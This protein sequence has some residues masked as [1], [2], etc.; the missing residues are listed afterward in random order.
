MRNRASCVVHRAVLAAGLVVGVGA[1]FAA[2][3]TDGSFVGA[4]DVTVPSDKNK[5]AITDSAHQGNYSAAMAFNNEYT[6]YAGRYVVPVSKIPY[7]VRYQF[8]NDLQPKLCGYSITPSTDS[9][10]TPSRTPKSWTF[11]GSN[12]GV[13]WT[14]LGAES[15]VTGWKKG[16]TRY[17]TADDTAGYTYFQ[18]HVTTHNG[19]SAYASLGEVE[20]Y[21]RDVSVNVVGEPA[22]YG[23]AAGIVYGVDELID[24]GTEKTFSVA[25]N[26]TV[27][28]ED[29]SIHYVPVSDG[30]RAVYRGYRFEDASEATEAAD[31]SFTRTLAGVKQNTLTWRWQLRN[32]TIATAGAGGVVK[33]GPRAPGQQATLWIDDDDSVTLEAVPDEGYKFDSWSGDVPD[34]S[35]VNEPTITVPGSIKRN[36]TATF[37]EAHHKATTLIFTPI[38]TEVDWD[39]SANAWNG[40]APGDG[41][42]ILIP[43]LERATTLTLT[44]DTP[45]LAKIDIGKNVTLVVANWNTR[46]LVTNTFVRN[47]GAIAVKGALSMDA[48]SNRVWIVGQN[49][50]IDAGGKITA[51]EAGYAARQG[52]GWTGTSCPDYYGGVYGG[53]QGYKENHSA[54]K[55][56]GSAEWP[57]DPGT[58]GSGAAGGGAIRIDL[59]GTLTVNGTITANGGASKHVNSGVNSGGGSGGGIAIACETIIG[60]GTVRANGGEFT[61]SGGGGG[62]T[63]GGRVAVRYDVTKQAAAGTCVVRFEARGA[64][65]RNNSDS[66]HNIYAGT[67]GSLWF[68]DTR[69][70]TTS[71]V[72]LAGVLESA[73]EPVT[74]AAEG[75][76]VFDGCWLDVPHAAVALD[77]A[78]DLVVTGRYCREYGVRLTNAAVSVGRDLLVKGC[79]F[80][81]WSSEFAVGRDVRLVTAKANSLRAAG[82]LCIWAQPTNGTDRAVGCAVDVAGDVTVGQHCSYKPGCHPQD[83]SIVVLNCRDLTVD[84]GG[85]VDASRRGWASMK[86]PGRYTAY[87]GAGVGSSYGGLGGHKSGQPEAR[88]CYGSRRAPVDPGSG[89]GKDTSA[90]TPGYAGGGVVR[91]IVSRNL[92]IDGTVKADA[93]ETGYD[94]SYYIS[95]GGSGGS[96]YLTCNTLMGETGTVTA[97]GGTASAGG[98]GGRIAVRYRID[99]SSLTEACCDVSGAKNNKSNGEIADGHPGTVFWEPIRGM[100][101]I[102][103]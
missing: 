19:D 40:K 31:E 62:G 10:E 89:S 1:A 97:K 95:N 37:K 63:G 76:F 39:D 68:S 66:A 99:K 77:V 84:A 13:A 87:E 85:F 12:D 8:K 9:N 3:V 83:A 43:S 100:R 26:L 67:C 71:P 33:L 94:P 61:G 64:T 20:F 35:L 54:G 32:R 47:G 57:E 72:R 78:G 55:L 81:T 102:V 18:L 2:E 28:D 65:G 29:S 58:G 7:W 74:I 27:D 70:L 52:P 41:D 23:T 34:A 24:R 51:D 4:Y 56:Y 60:S 16:V 79:T 101:M 49:L 75:D 14:V 44:H 22:N 103:R 82:D 17:F 91:V 36:L 15:D 92:T 42:T 86:G 73:V 46:L 21:S 5:N 59:A 45:P 38:G 98:G 96:V 80:E 25:A 50:T 6:S 48:M 90:N 93:C 88:P 53:W 11:E 69:F 30:V